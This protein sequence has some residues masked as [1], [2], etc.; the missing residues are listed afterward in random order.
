MSAEPELKTGS[1]NGVCSHLFNVGSNQH[2]ADPEERIARSRE[3]NREHARRTRLR[4]KAQLQ[5]LQAR[6]EELERES[7]ALKQSLEECNIASILL[8][9]SKSPSTSS[10]ATLREKSLYECSAI[11]SSKPISVGS[12]TRGRRKKFISSTLKN[13]DEKSPQFKFEIRGQST[14]IGGTGKTHINWK[15]G[16]YCD[17]NGDQKQL[18]NEELETLR[19]ERNRMHAKMTRDRKKNFISGLSCAIKKLEHENNKMRE[20]LSLQVPKVEPHALPMEHADNYDYH[21][22]N[23]ELKNEESAN[24]LVGAAEESELS[25]K[26][27]GYNVVA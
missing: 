3:R 24:G 25:E 12:S 20:A 16:V 10:E 6:M 8:G 7:R 5:N 22:Y 23:S 17:K 21:V 11:I 26:V 19:R 1:G 18:T 13:D 15:T 27:I 14:I 4:K 9:L 2:E